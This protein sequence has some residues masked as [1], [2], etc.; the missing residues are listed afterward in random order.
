MRAP[1]ELLVF[2]CLVVGIFPAQVVGPLLAAAA[3]PVVGG[4]LPNTAWPSG[5]A[6]TRR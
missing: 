4:T 6:G 2:T 5:T 1:V 3:L